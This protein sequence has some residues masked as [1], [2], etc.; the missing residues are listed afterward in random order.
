[1]FKKS[2]GFPGIF[3]LGL[4]CVP[5][6]S[7]PVSSPAPRVL[8]TRYCVT[9]HNEKL[10]TAGLMLDKVDFDHIGDGAEV[11]EKVIRKLRAGDMP[12]AGLPRPNS[13]VV[14]GLV[15]SLEKSLDALAA[16]KPNPGR[17]AVHRL[18]RA[19]YANAIRDLLGIE[20]D[21]ETLLPADES[22][23]GFDNNAEILSLSPLLLDRYLIAARRISRLAVGDPNVRPAVTGFDSPKAR[24]QDQRE[25]ED[26]P[27][28]SRGGIAIRYEF[29]LDGEYVVKIHLQK[30]D[31]SPVIRGLEEP[32]E[33]DVRLDGARIKL[34]K[35]G[36]DPPGHERKP[37]D[38]EAGLQIRFKAAAG[39]GVLGV[40]FVEDRVAPEG[41]VQPRNV[42][43]FHQRGPSPV[44]DVQGD[45]GVESV[46]IAGPYDAHAAA[47]TPSR[48]KIFICRPTGKQDEEACA[49]RI[50]SSL[51]RRAYRRPVSDSDVQSLVRL[52][53]T[54]L[55]DGFEAGIETALQGILVSREFLF[56]IERDPSE[57]APDTVYRISDLE[58]ASRMSF[59]LWSSIPDDQLLDLAARGKLK[60]PQVIEQQ[61][62]RMLA[63]R[64]SDALVDNFFG[65]WLYLRSMS[66]A[67]PD[68]YAFPDFD[69]DLR[70]AFEQ[71]TRL[72]C[73]S[74]LRED[75][76]AMDLLTANYTFVN[77]RL[78]RQY[79]IPGVY[80]SRFRRVTLTDEA[81][82]GLLGKGSI[83][84]VTSYPNRTSPVLRGKW[85]LE[86][87]LGAPP[88][89][90]PAN[91]PDLKEDEDMQ[92]LTMRQRMEQHRAN[93]ACA[94]CHSRMDPLGFA[95]DNF[96]AIGT[97]R[98]T[99]VSNI[100]PDG[101][102]HIG[103]PVAAT[104]IDSS[105]ELPGGIKLKGPSELRTILSS[106]RDE[107][108]NTVIDKLLTYALGRGVEFYD[109]PA[110]R[111]I[112][113]ETAPGGYRW[114]AMIV[115][116]V[117][118][119]PFQMRKSAE[120]PSNSALR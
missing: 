76:P 6:G 113:Q 102:A 56:R 109:E 63:D 58:L 105:G 16:A 53:K 106:H 50:L 9:C 57:A 99:E 74:M 7:Q 71:E 119:A 14:N 89:H 39:P 85:I 107:F 45:P 33:L 34:F 90:K 30:Y 23:F 95:L 79:K 75:H 32:H 27:F 104:A 3:L 54:G 100:N 115:S 51:A 10:K 81:R 70:S 37:A 25:S 36:G 97:W 120:Q 87:I 114:S 72:F 35:I 42:M 19:E 82:I 103:T 96:D 13:A 40:A 20:I 31:R 101:L 110:V 17:P 24:L 84:T 68:Q 62:R 47:D 111:R 48:R 43:S 80:G 46:S 116:I 59:F 55:A 21:G 8:I 92:G 83:L 78:A 5:A 93:P 38:V 69:E 22:G 49:K 52:Y 15:E 117:N 61:V 67:A 60:D 4:A 64:R 41:I 18:N 73:R 77:E 12:P 29:P 11:W 66:S 44:Y 28:G 98:T 88:P 112:M 65:Q 86:N 26:L 94:S 108:A 91:V 2:I 1:M 118:S